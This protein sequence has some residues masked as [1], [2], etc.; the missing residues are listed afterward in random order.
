MNNSKAAR[1][2]KKEAA[3]ERESH[4]KV[5]FIKE[6]GK[7]HKLPQGVMVDMVSNILNISLESLN[8]DAYFVKARRNK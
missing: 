4:L 8:V 6:T 3:S 1:I 7:V 2:V 5:R